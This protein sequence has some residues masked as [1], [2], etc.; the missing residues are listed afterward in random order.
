MF[1]AKAE[2]QTTVC[3][4]YN[5]IKIL[6]SM[7]QLLFA[8]STIYRTR[9]DQLDLYGYAA[10][11]LTVVPYAW[12]SFINLLGNLM[13]PQYDTMFVVKSVGVWALPLSWRRHAAKTAAT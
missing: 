11:G 6:V 2:P 4:S 8:I 9:G 13:R 12:M 7:A 5:F 3:C 10:F 1:R